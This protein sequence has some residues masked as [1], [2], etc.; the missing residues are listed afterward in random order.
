[1]NIYYFE[2]GYYIPFVFL[3]LLI[4]TNDLFLSTIITLKL[5]QANYY[6]HFAY[7]YNHL[8]GN[9]VMLKQFVRFTD[10]GHLVSFLFYLFPRLASLAFNIHFVITFAYWIGVIFFSLKDTDDITS[11]ALNKNYEYMWIVLNHSLPL[12]LVVNEISGLD[13]KDELFHQNDLYFSLLW[14]WTWLVFIYLPWRLITEDCVYSVLAYEKPFIF[15]ASFM[16]M[17]H[18]V[19]IL[20]N[21]VGSKL[22]QVI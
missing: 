21:Y 15:K 17:T 14:G 8:P 19:M 16:I 13:F 3:F 1:M 22:I 10:S 4:F 5:Y 2:N 11:V 18:L 20:A 9:F 12:I 6:F 7:L